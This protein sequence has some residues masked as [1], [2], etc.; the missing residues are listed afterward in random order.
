MKRYFL[1]L[2]CSF[3]YSIGYGQTC[4]ELMKYVKSKSYPTTFQSPLSDA[5]S[6][7]SFFE[8]VED[9]NFYYY[10]I[11]CFKRSDYSCVEY[12]YQVG[13]NTKLN[14]SLNYQKSAGHAFWTY[15]Q[16]YNKSLRCGANFKD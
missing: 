3:F 9:M 6:K 7:V 15:I 2:I 10:A 1:I 16:P 13:S 14:Y 5:I 8:I 4:D 12:I 11:V